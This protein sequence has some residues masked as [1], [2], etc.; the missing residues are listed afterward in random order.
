LEGRTSAETGK[1]ATALSA[2]RRHRLAA[3]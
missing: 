1:A 3:R 2:V